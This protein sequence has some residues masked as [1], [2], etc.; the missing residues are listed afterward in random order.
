MEVGLLY[1]VGVKIQVRDLV[2]FVGIVVPFAPQG[3][4]GENSFY[5][6]PG[7]KWA[8]ETC[9]GC[10]KQRHA[11]EEPGKVQGRD[12]VEIVECPVCTWPVG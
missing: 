5:R 12:H 7:G 11:T 6:G 8:H 1:G 4:F 10:S 9:V 2:R 3:L